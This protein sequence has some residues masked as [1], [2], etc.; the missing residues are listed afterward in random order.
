MD[1]CHMKLENQAHMNRVKS[2][3]KKKVVR[4][5]FSIFFVTKG[6]F[7]FAKKKA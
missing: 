5:T 2:M 3:Q 6:T 7:L 4:L 1:P